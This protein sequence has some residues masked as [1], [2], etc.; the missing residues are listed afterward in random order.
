MDQNSMELFKKLTKRNI[1]LPYSSQKINL[2]IKQ[3]LKQLKTNL[4]DH[5]DF[6]HWLILVHGI[7]R[8]H[9]ICGKM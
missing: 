6:L 9:K 1:F 3:S 5:I 8:I 2:N 4:I 7:M